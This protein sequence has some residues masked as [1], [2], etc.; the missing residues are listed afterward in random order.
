[1]SVGLIVEVFV[2]LSIMTCRAIKALAFV[3]RSEL[4]AI[5]GKKFVGKQHD[6]SRGLVNNI[7]FGWTAM[8]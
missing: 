6:S 8:V 1:M 2:L 3:E 7:A 4:F 5:V